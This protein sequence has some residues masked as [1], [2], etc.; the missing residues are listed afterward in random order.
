MGFV[1]GRSP[2]FGS[3]H[4]LIDVVANQIVGLFW[5]S[6]LDEDRCVCFPGS[7]HLT[8]S[9]GH[10]CK[11]T[12]LSPGCCWEKNQ[13]KEKDGN[14]PLSSCVLMDP[15]GSEGSLQPYILA[16]RTLNLYCLPS[17]RSNAA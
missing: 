6:P 1:I 9:G 2:G 15:V 5:R 14:T 13:T 11:Q 12:H 16:D 8:G 3:F 7:N 10:T 4:T 17:A